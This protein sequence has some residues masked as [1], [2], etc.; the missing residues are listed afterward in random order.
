MGQEEKLKQLE[1]LSLERGAEWEW[2]GYALGSIN[3]REVLP[4]GHHTAVYCF[5][6]G[7]YREGKQWCT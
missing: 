4:G 3:L 6:V 7:R 5:H 1:L 2:Y